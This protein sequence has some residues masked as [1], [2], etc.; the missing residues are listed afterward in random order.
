MDEP[1]YPIATQV[2]KIERFSGNRTLSPDD[3]GRV[4]RGE[5][6]SNVTVTV[7]NNLGEGFTV[8]FV[9]YASG[10]ITLSA[11]SGATKRAGG[12]ATSAQY[13]RGS[14]IVTKNADGASAESFVG[15]DFA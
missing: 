13:Q 12:T 10:T 6:S 8:G 7:P 2:G 15:G 1:T 4:F 9:Q 3:N 5:D 11:G 14:L